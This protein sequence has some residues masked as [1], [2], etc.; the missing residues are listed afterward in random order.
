MKNKCQEAVATP[1]SEK[2]YWGKSLVFGKKVNIW[3]SW[4]I[5]N[6]LRIIII[7]IIIIII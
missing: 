4:N 3:W 5:C 6:N 1:F 7:I 2:K